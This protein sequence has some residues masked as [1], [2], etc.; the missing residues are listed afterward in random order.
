MKATIKEGNP[1]KE[2]GNGILMQNKT[3]LKTIVLVTDW[4]TDPECFKGV[5]ITGATPGFVS[6]HEKTYFQFF[7]G[8]IELTQ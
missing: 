2:G 4:Y 1:K 7:E 5:N 8:V 6:L 3:N